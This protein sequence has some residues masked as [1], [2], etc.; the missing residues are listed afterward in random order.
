[1]EAIQAKYDLPSPKVDNSNIFEHLQ[2]VAPEGEVVT[3][4]GNLQEGKN[5]ATQSFER[6]Y[7]NHYVAHAP[8][9]NHTAV[10]KVEKGKATVWAS[11]QS[12]F[13]ARGDVARALGFPEEKVRVITPFVGGGFGGKNRNQQAVE[14]ARLSKLTGKPVQVAWSRQEEFFYDTFRPAA[15][16]KV[17]SGLGPGHKVVFWDFE[18][19]YAGSRSSEPFYNIPHNRVISRG[20]W[21]GNDGAHPFAVGAWRAPGSNTNVFAMESQI[22]IMASQAGLD[23]LQFRLRNLKDERMKRV[24]EAVA[25]KFG[26][27]LS[28]APSGKGYGLACTDYLNTYLATLAEVEVDEGSGEIQV[29]RVV[30]AQDT[31]EVINPKGVKLQVEGCITMGLGY[32]LTEEVRF[33]GGEILDENFGTYQIPRFSW[34][35]QIETVLVRNPEIPPQGCGEPAITPMGAVIAN[36]VYDA[37]GARLFTLPMTPERV[38]QALR[39][40]NSG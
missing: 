31:G 1:M 27:S 16:I 18:I 3:Q 37:T 40:R 23:P 29:K 19:I 24:L 13:G 36:A 33:R 39:N 26:Y 17:Q 9:E 35:P 12:P 30:C 15:V 4:A 2:K 28:K 25:E 34:T 6:T 5:M 11:T 32:V 10:A 22:D 20:G 38:K 8:L 7:Y 14:A 21:F